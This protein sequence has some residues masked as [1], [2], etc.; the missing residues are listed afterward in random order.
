MG[1]L[2]DKAMAEEEDNSSSTN[3]PQTDAGSQSGGGSLLDQAMSAV[4]NAS[5][6]TQ[7][8]VHQQFHEAASQ[9]S[10]DDLQ[11]AATN[12]VQS[13]PADQQ[14]Q[15]AQHLANQGAAQGAGVPADTKEPS[16]IGKMVAWVHKNVP[17]G[18]PGALGLIGGAGVAAGGAYVASQNPG[19]VKDAVS[20]TTS[21]GSSVLNSGTAGNVFNALQN[22]VKGKF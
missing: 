14:A 8:A 2:L 16:Q 19:A 1:S 5:D 13:L 17:G 7:S 3:A 9:L 22:A 15:L 11:S 12:A 20:D 21:A 18:V 6:Q 4:G 10:P